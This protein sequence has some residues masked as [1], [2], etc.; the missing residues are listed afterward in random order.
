[1]RS[2]G[3]IW[4]S[5]EPMDLEFGVNEFDEPLGD[6]FKADSGFPCFIEKAS[7]SQAEVYEDG[8]YSKYSF[9]IWVEYAYA[10]QMEWLRKANMCKI[11]YKDKDPLAFKIISV[12][13]IERLNRIKI[14]V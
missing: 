10:K 3:L 11:Q 8:V 12:S 6:T 13:D 9:I 7:E 4:I 1:M 2:N 5:E 14:M